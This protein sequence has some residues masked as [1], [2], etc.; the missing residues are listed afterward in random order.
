MHD[1]CKADVLLYILSIYIDWS[2]QQY[3][4]YALHELS[5]SVGGFTLLI[6]SGLLWSV[7][8]KFTCTGADECKAVKWMAWHVGVTVWKEK[9][10]LVVHFKP[11][12]IILL[13]EH[14]SQLK[15]D[16]Q[17]LTSSQPVKKKKNSDILKRRLY[18]FMPSPVPLVFK[19]WL[20]V[21]IRQMSS[22]YMTNITALQ[23]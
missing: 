17:C 23:M 20:W 9:W 18:R 1:K 8:D 6:S 11:H 5:D 13:S 21:Y 2:K 10:H 16:L 22:S 7:L 3:D 12:K 19:I 14:S 4:W 15:M